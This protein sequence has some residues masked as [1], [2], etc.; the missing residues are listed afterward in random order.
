MSGLNRTSFA[1]TTP[2]GFAFLLVLC[3]LSLVGPQAANAQYALRGTIVD[4]TNDQPLPQ[5]TIQLAGSVRGTVSNAEGQFLITIPTLPATLEVRYIGYVSQ[6]VEITQ[7]DLSGVSIRMERA[8]VALDE[9]VVTGENPAEGIVRNAIQARDRMR[10]YVDGTYSDVYTRFLLYA[11]FDLVQMNE[12]VRASWWTPEGGTR[13]VIRAERS[14]PSRSGLFRF[15]SP[16]PVPN[17]L[18]HDV[19]VMGAAYAG[20][21]HPDAIDLYQFTQGGTREFDGRRVIEIYFRPRS[22][23][24]PAFSGSMAIMDSV[25]T[26]LNVTAR[27]WPGTDILPPVQSHDL[28]M[29][30]HFS[31]IGDSLSIPQSLVVQGSVTFGRAG[32]AYPTAR[33]HQVTGLSLHVVNPPVPDSLRSSGPAV[34]RDPLAAFNNDLFLRN[35]SYIPATP[36]EA[37]QIATLDPTMTLHRAFRPEGLLANYTAFDVTDDP[38][39]EESSRLDLAERITG[40]DWFWYNRVDG[41]HPGFGYGGSWGDGGIWRTSAGY[42][43]ERK[44]PS[45]KVEGSVPWELGP[46]KGF[47]GGYASDATSVVARQEGLGRFVPGMSTYLGW[48]DIYDYFDLRKQR[49]SLDLALGPLPALISIRA[50][51]E[52]HRS[53]TKMS[54]FNG[55]L[56]RNVQRENPAIERGLLRST[57]VGVLVGNR[58]RVSME[59][60]WERSPGWHLASDF[61]FTR[62]EARATARAQTFY[63][64]RARPNWMR[65]TAL[66]GT[67]NG[68]LPVQRQFGLS[69]SAGPFAEFTGFRTLPNGRFLADELLGVF[70]AHDFTTALFEK[71][72]LWWLAEQGWGIHVFGGHAFS[73][74]PDLGTF[75]GLHHEVGVGMS[76]PFGLPFRVDLAKGTGG[77]WYFKFGRPLK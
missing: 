33:Y 8:S 39:A 46:L 52:R 14:Q 53:L 51:N 42:S 72:G 7:Q 66:G 13:E 17:F 9:L 4:A 74:S 21:L 77:G 15:A 43:I 63:R 40:G 75:E 16:H 45:Y 1:S 22:A 55:W 20:P 67:S 60:T 48:D 34:Q 32:V 31:T 6:L 23:T 69:G 36:R 37:E 49:I 38:P 5:A 29:E 54:D 25:W 18:D 28:V 11:D 47:L 2:K 26:V 62:I 73:S 3:V 41:W 24:F 35:P 65:V 56:F 50:N 30:Q 64:R 27:P 57:E 44:R 10:Q 12:S 68:M 58:E 59:V 71:A 76:Y 61:D 19:E 70:W